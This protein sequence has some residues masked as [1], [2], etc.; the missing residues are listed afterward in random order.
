M[1]TQRLAAVKQAFVAQP[2]PQLLADQM[3]YTKYFITALKSLC[4]VPD[5]RGDNF[6][7]ARTK[8]LQAILQASI[9]AGRKRPRPIQSAAGAVV[10]TPPAP[11]PQALQTASGRHAFGAV[12]PQRQPQGG[13]PAAATQQ[14]ALSAQQKVSAAQHGSVAHFLERWIAKS[15]EPLQQQLRQL[16]AAYHAKGD[17]S[18][19]AS[20]SGRGG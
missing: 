8:V 20:A 13:A 15:A 17:V 3:K 11:V 12:P 6:T 1:L 14:A 2:A 5:V 19:Q 16:L 10:P 9:A 18:K 7:N 4:F